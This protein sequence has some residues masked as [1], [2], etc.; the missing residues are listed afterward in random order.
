MLDLPKVRIVK[1]SFLRIAGIAQGLVI[2]DGIFAHFILWGDV[3]DFQGFDFGRDATELATIIGPLQ[4]FV[5]DGT[6]NRTTI[7]SA[8]FPNIQTALLNEFGNC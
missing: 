1:I 3:V 4:H 6:W 5:T 2:V 8:V 7:L